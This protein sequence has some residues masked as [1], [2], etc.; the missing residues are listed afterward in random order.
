MFC[1]FFLQKERGDSA[2]IHLFSL[3]IDPRHWYGLHFYLVNRQTTKETHWNL[4]AS[5][6][7][8]AVHLANVVCHIFKVTCHVT[9]SQITCKESQRESA[10]IE[11]ALPHLVISSIVSFLRA[12]ESRDVVLTCILIQ[13][14]GSLPGGGPSQT[15]LSQLEHVDYWWWHW[16]RALAIGHLD[17]WRIAMIC[18]FILISSASKQHLKS[19]NK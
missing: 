8:G 16:H 6:V 3:K 11:A 5:H 19:A 15:T 7:I 9:S 14:P 17:H 2:V 12:T 1:F 10:G 4:L 13:F 18:D